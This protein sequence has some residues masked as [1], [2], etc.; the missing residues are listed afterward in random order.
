MHKTGLL[1]VT[2]NFRKFPY[3]ISQMTFG[4]GLSTDRRE[5]HFR[6]K[7]P[8]PNCFLNRHACKQGEA[9]TRRSTTVCEESIPA[10]QAKRYQPSHLRKPTYINQHWTTAA[11]QRWPYGDVLEVEKTSKCFGGQFHR[12]CASKTGAGPEICTKHKVCPVFLESMN[13]QY[14]SQN[15]PF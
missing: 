12:Q 8:I 10:L 4:N 15:G 7:Q 13:V 11:I 2:Q 6:Q 1:R 3:W 14:V 9:G 5:R